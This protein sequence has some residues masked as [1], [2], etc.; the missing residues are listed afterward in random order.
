MKRLY[1][2]IVIVFCATCALS[3]FCKHVIQDQNKEEQRPAET[4]SEEQQELKNI[5]DKLTHYAEENQSSFH[6]F[7]YKNVAS[8]IE[9][10]D[11][12]VEDAL[13]NL[14]SGIKVFIAKTKRDMEVLLSLLDTYPRIAQKMDQEKLK[15]LRAAVEEEKTL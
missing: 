9:I 14:D 1:V 4:L 10:L 13:I 2:F 5:Q 7:N 8:S 15:Q 11:K 3:V 12:M 6:A